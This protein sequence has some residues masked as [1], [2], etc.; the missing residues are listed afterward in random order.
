M[1]DRSQLV[2]A[3]EA[4]AAAAAAEGARLELVVPE[5]E[6]AEAE[7]EEGAE[8]EAVEEGVEEEAEVV[9]EEVSLVSL[10]IFPQATLS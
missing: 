2:E 5:W 8:A 7:G 3:A 6:H 4:A 1:T 10:L 9:V